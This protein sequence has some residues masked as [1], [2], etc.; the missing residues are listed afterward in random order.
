MSNNDPDSGPIPSSTPQWVGLVAFV[1]LIAGYVFLVVTGHSGDALVAKGITIAGFFGIA[2]FTADRFRSV[3]RKLDTVTQQTNGALD[4]R[5][6]SAIEQAL[7]AH[8]VKQ[9]AKGARRVTT[10]DP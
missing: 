4:A 3:N 6:Q 7:A 10:R 2:G 9:Q 1:T 8:E 5:I